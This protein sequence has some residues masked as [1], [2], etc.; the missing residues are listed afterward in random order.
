MRYILK[1]FHVAFTV[2]HVSLFFLWRVTTLDLFIPEAAHA[3][4]L[5]ITKTPGKDECTTMLPHF[6]RTGSV[7]CFLLDS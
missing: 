1:P 5:S 7:I 4:C 2:Q 6:M 3:M